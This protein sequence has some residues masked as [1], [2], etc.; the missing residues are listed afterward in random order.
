M[1]YSDYNDDVS[2]TNGPTFGAAHIAVMKCFWGILREYFSYSE[3]DSKLEERLEL[4]RHFLQPSS[5]NCLLEY[6]GEYGDRYEIAAKWHSQMLYPDCELVNGVGEFLP[7][8]KYVV[9]ASSLDWNFYDDTSQYDFPAVFYSPVEIQMW[10][11]WAL[12]KKMHFQPRLKPFFTRFINELLNEAE[13]II[14]FKKK[15][16]SEVPWEFGPAR[17]S[18]PNAA[19]WHVLTREEKMNKWILQWLD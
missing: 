18:E 12:K 13:L 4:F 8:E 10:F 15:L 11:L 5:E 14:L 2:P 17:V 9:I 3:V 16:S 19:L 7:G 1:L 6:Y